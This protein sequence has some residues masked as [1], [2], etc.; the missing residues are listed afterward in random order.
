ME[1]QW[2]LACE[3]QQGAGVTYSSVPF[4]VQ[5]TQAFANTKLRSVILIPKMTIEPHN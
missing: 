3:R 4:D 2:Q 1:R 5:I